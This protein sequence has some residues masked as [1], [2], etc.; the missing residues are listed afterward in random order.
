MNNLGAGIGRP[1]WD[2]RYGFYLT[3]SDSTAESGVGEELEEPIREPRV[4]SEQAPEA[5]KEPTPAP[6]GLPPGPNPPEDQALAFDSPVLSTGFK[7]FRPAI[8]SSTLSQTGNENTVPK[9]LEVDSQA[10]LGGNT[11][12]VNMSSEEGTFGSSYRNNAHAI[13]A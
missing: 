10:R 8:P 4:A 12:L 7:P 1:E 13:Y 3:V 6:L 11:V 9:V 5:E 2:D